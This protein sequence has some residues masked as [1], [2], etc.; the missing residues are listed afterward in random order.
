MPLVPAAAIQLLERAFLLRG[1]GAVTLMNDYLAVYTVLFFA[2]LGQLNRAVITPRE[3]RQ[4][5]LLLSKPI[6]RT[7]FLA[8]RCQ[9][10]LLATALLGVALGVACALAAAPYAGQDVT[11]LGA[12]GATLVILAL[13]LMELAL[14]NVVF[15]LL[16]DGFQALLV[17]FVVW[18]LPLI[19]TSVFIYRPDVFE[20]H[21]LATQLLVMPANLVWLDADVLLV[22]GALLL[23]AGLVCALL[24]R[25]AGA[26]F[27]HVEL[28]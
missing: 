15:L 16:R 26:V 27:E 18:V 20:G 10:V 7:D 9:P 6:R 22:G 28:R 8:A 13:V 17:A 12:F 25:V 11:P 2:G 5:E 24:A 4:L 21:P 19:G 3:Q 1:M 23:V 14:L